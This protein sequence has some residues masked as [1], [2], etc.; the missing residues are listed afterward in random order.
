MAKRK[1]AVST[2]EIERLARERLGYE[3]LRSGQ[4]ETIRLVLSG[5]DTLSVMPTGSGKS[6]IYQIAALFIDGPTV[7]VSPL[8]ALQKDQL[9]SIQANDLAGAAV[10]NSNVRAAEKRDA[11]ERLGDG[12]LEFM[13]MAPEQMANEATMARLLGNP[14]SLFVVD[15]AHCLSECGHDFRPDYARLGKF[16]EQLGSPR[17]LA[18]TATAAPQVR[19]EIVKRLG[20]KNERTVVW[21]FDRPN[22][23]LEVE[24]C[25]DEETKRRLVV[26]RVTDLVRGGDGGERASGIVYVA[27]RGHAED[28]ARWLAEEANIRAAYYHAGMKKDQRNEVQDRFMRGDDDVIVATNAFGMGVDK[29]DVWFVVHYDVPEAL[30]AYYQ[31]VGRAGRDGRPARALLLYRPEDAGRRRAMAASGKLAEEQV[32]AVLEAVAE[33]RKGVD[34]K[35][36]AAEMKAEEELSGAKVAKAIN[37]LEEVGAVAVTADGQVTA[38]DRRVDVEAAAGRAVEEQEG[39]RQYRLGRVEMIKGYAETLECRRHYLLNYFGEA[40]DSVCGNCDNCKTGL[41]KRHIEAREADGK[42]KPF[43]IDAKVM[44]KKFGAGV[45]RRYEGDKVVILFDTQGYKELVTRVVVEHGL[46]EL[47][48]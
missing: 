21:G 38:T 31:E 42:G 11:F 8:V 48:G 15:E 18:L 28:V 36:L 1:T 30:D 9:E 37:R 10:V 17:V 14:P 47:V 29:A 32:E 22:I 45:V 5:H 44:H 39:Y 3:D 12:T 19:E 27:T 41:S 23:S 24:Q 2:A 43:P 4:L 25:P 26:E 16:I 46:V 6:A 7:I 20:M 35:E 13:F 33:S 34:V 40:S